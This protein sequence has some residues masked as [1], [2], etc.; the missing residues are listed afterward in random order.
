MLSGDNDNT[1]REEEA[2]NDAAYN[3]EQADILAEI[4]DKVA[5][6]CAHNN[7]PPSLP[8]DGNQEYTPNPPNGFP[9]IHSEGPLWTL[10][11]VASPQVSDWF[12]LDGAKIVA[13]IEKEVSHEAERAASLADALA[14]D[15]D[16]NFQITGMKAIHGYADITTNTK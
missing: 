6:K 2:G 9:T 4:K 16:E 15:I 7:H 12:H 5:Q 8:T 14:R 1:P 3:D 13:T 11:N 10:N